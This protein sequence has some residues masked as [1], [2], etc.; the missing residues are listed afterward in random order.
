[1]SGKAVM[2]SYLGTKTDPMQHTQFMIVKDF[3]QE[4]N[5]RFL[6]GFQWKAQYLTVT[7]KGLVYWSHSLSEFF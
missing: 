3:V 5:V 4:V 1:M 7:A 6:N 2:L